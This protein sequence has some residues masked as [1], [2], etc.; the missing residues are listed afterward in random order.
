M[1]GEF[2]VMG[3]RICTI[4]YPDRRKGPVVFYARCILLAL[5]LAALGFALATTTHRS[6]AQSAGPPHVTLISRVQDGPT[7]RVVCLVE[8]AAPV[9]VV[10]TGPSTTN[11]VED[12]AGGWRTTVAASLDT[13][14]GS[15]LID[16]VS[17]VAPLRCTWLPIGA[18]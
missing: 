16:G 11:P 9:A 15:L 17:V 5:I 4:W 13:C 14:H 18:R 6:A 12:G 3:T 10:A 8:S 2:M 7:V 1:D